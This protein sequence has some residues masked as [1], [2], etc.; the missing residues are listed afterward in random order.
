MA[1]P[2][3]SNQTLLKHGDGA[4]PEVF[5]AVGAISDIN[6]PNKKADVIDTSNHNTTTGYKTKLASLKDGGEIT[7]DVFWDP[8][9]ATHNQTSG[10]LDALFESQSIDNWQITEGTLSP[11]N[12]WSFQAF[13]SGLGTK[14]AVAGAMKASVTLTVTGKPTHS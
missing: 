10:G 3:N 1:T 6:G 4:S 8:T 11:V 7:F 5:T 13:V 2:R 12:K 14:Y 9:D